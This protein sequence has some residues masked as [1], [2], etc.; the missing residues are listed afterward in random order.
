MNIPKGKCSYCEETFL[1]CKCD[2]FH[3]NIAEQDFTLD[4]KERAALLDYFINRA[5]WIS[6]EFDPEVHK[7]IR[8]LQDYEKETNS[9]TTIKRG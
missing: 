5:G 8:K 9:S 3:P 7:I 6:H 4:E 1:N 2:Q